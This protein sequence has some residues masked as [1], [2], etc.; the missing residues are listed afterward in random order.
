MELSRNISNRNFKSYIWHAI[1][2]ALAINFMDVDTV[3]PAMLIHSGGGTFLVGLMSA[4]MLG[5]SRMSQLF[6]TPFLQNRQHKKIFLLVGINSR[7]FSLLG[8]ALLFYLS[9]QITQEWVIIFIFMLIITFSIG[10]AFAEIPYTDII[11][12]SIFPESRKRFFS[13]KQ[14]LSGV[15]VFLSA[16]AAQQ[17]LHHFTF[18]DNYL[19][20]FLLA[21]A[22]L[23]L[24]S[25]G[26]YSIIEFI[27]EEHK[28]ERIPNLKVFVQK[29][30]KELKEHQ[31][32]TF[33]ILVV[34][35]LGVGL[36]ILPF[37]ILF[38]KTK[39]VVNA[40]V[41][42]ELLV[43]KTIGLVLTSFVIYQFSNKFKYKQLLYFSISLLILMV[44][45]AIIFME[46]PFV[47]RLL[48]LCGG[49]FV[50][51]FTITK[52]GLLLE[53]STDQNR[54]FYTG[55]TGAS[56]LLLTIFP[57][58]SGIIIGLWGFAYFFGLTLFLLLLSGYFAYHL[59]CYS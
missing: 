50:S 32:L 39:M 15:S 9:P 28:T 51:L 40:T 58:I 35:T 52:A 29:I 6:F 33:Y 14:L 16:L 18:P 5:G 17:L 2:A 19:A 47:F 55:L 41:V 44:I 26:F 30:V 31:Q 21:A 1:F 56:N 4:I 42:G 22:F 20:M 12:K 53:I 7:I 13:L 3:L 59:K 27:K 25:I 57:L 23:G 11:G 54:A 37:I 10:G 24:A 8:L 36:A 49:I 45:T 38:A 43:F 34:N 48:F 46:H